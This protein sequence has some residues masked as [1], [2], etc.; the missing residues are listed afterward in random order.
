MQRYLL[1]MKMDVAD[2]DDAVLLTVINENTY[3]KLKKSR[4][5]ATW[6]Q[7][8]YDLEYIPFSDIED[9]IQCWKGNNI[10]VTPITDA[11]VELFERLNVYASAGC[12]YFLDENDEEFDID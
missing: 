8:D 7:W 5:A 9:N 11:E 3:N 4:V 12:F 1:N 10:T 6:G 2:E